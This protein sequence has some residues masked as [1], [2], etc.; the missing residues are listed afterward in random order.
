MLD[1]LIS[2]RML[3]K[4]AKSEKVK[5]RSGT[6]KQKTK[7]KRDAKLWE[8]ANWQTGKLDELFGTG[9]TSRRSFL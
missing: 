7:E 8:T 4:S 1:D 3:V 5:D 9:K 2:E 6:D